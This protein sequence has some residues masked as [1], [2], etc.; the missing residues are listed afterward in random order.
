MGAAGLGRVGLGEEGAPPLRAGSYTETRAELPGGETGPDPGVLGA[1]L[2]PFPAPH[3]A[4]LFLWVGGMTCADSHN[5]QPHSFISGIHFLGVG[6]G[7]LGLPLGDGLPGRAW[8]GGQ[9]SPCP[10]SLQRT[11]PSP[12]G[13]SLTHRRQLWFGRQ[14]WGRTASE[15]RR[16][17]IRLGRTASSAT[18]LNLLSLYLILWV[19]APKLQT[20]A[21][22]PLQSQLLGCVPLPRTRELAT[23]PRAESYL[24]DMPFTE[25][26]RFE[27]RELQPERGVIPPGDPPRLVVEKARGVWAQGPR[28]SLLPL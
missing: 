23:H 12:A 14:S 10:P 2:V 16:W 13:P 21:P 3:P 11:W 15:D 27:P 20:A 17:G 5:P 25:G 4:S 18:H 26:P 24:G 28:T 19:V 7:I 8:G 22:R 9:S 6:E 1:V